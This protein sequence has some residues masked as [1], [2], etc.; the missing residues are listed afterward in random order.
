VAFDKNL[1]KLRR[2]E[3]QIHYDAAY[4]FWDLRG[5]LAEKWAH[6]PHFGAYGT[7]PDSVT[8]SRKAGDS[9]LVGTYSL[10]AS[11]FLCEDTSFG[12]TK[13]EN[14]ALEWLGD[15]LK[16][17]KPRRVRRIY[18]KVIY[19]YPIRDRQRVSSAILKEYPQIAEFTPREYDEVQRGVTFHARRKSPGMEVLSTGQLGVYGPDQARAILQAF[20]E[21]DEQWALGLVYDCNK[22]LVSDRLDPSRELK[23][24]TTDLRR[25]SWDILSKSLM[26]VM[27]HA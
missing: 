22:T 25:E 7:G 18:S 1:L 13:S 21:A 10:K 14:L 20:T 3:V 16:A 9:S 5:V 8:L 12:I 17:L 4:L 19:S 26:R 2:Y 24:A 27:A 15:C 23:E 6:G 11:A